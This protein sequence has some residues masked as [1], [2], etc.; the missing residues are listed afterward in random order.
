MK[1][2]AN[3]TELQHELHELLAR[4]QGKRP[5]RE[6]IA[7]QLEDL[8]AR[9][10]GWMP[11]TS[12]DSKNIWIDAMVELQKKIQPIVSAL[13]EASRRKSIFLTDGAKRQLAKAYRTAQQLDQ[14]I[15]DWF[16]HMER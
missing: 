7:N 3:T 6:R 9:V 11:A 1:K 14:D 12:Y 4:A 8:S 2:V 15:A 13:D 10:A 5:S 16:E